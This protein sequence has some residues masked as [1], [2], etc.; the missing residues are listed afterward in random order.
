M[1]STATPP[2]IPL[3]RLVRS[4]RD[5]KR[6]ATRRRAMGKIVARLDPANMDELVFALKA[7]GVIEADLF[8]IAADAY[9]EH[10]A[11]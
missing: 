8:D 3:S 10:R 1:S 5:G 4:A 11:R 7:D 6:E 9:A 2:Q